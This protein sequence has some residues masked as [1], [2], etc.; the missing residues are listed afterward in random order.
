MN[1]KWIVGLQDTWLWAGRIW[2]LSSPY[3]LDNPLDGLFALFKSPFLLIHILV[4]TIL[5]LVLVLVLIHHPPPAPH[6]SF[7]NISIQPCLLIASPSPDIIRP[8]PLQRVRTPPPP[9]SITALH[10]TP[11]QHIP[12]ADYP[13]TPA[14]VTPAIAISVSER[15]PSSGRSVLPQPAYLGWRTPA[16]PP[17]MAT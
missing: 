5:V 14:P 9:P 16:P 17:L 15:I 6:L 7:H 13:H 4:L 8:R 11:S 2:A 10:S 3:T 12:S 1:T